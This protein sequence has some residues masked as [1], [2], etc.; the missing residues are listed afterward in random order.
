MELKMTTVCIYFDQAFR[1][2]H[3]VLDRLD[4]DRANRRPHGPSTNSVAA[5][6]THCCGMAPF[7]LE[8]VGVDAPTTRDRDAEF[9]AEATVTE[10]RARIDDLRARCEEMLGALESSSS[11]TYHPVRAELPGGDRSDPAIVLHVLEELFQH[12]GHME[13]TADALT[14]P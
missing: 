5:L 4:D 13:A 1:G 7:W 10:L 6:I 2:M 14:A 3:R 12:L 8:H 9:H 11:A